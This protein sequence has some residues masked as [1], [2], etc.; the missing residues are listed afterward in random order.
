MRPKALMLAAAALAALAGA[1]RA[2]ECTVKV[3]VVMPTSVDWGKP[4]AATT[5]WVAEL[6]NEAGGVDGCRVETILRDTQVDPKVG[7]DAARALVDL[8]KVQLLLGAVSSGVSMPILTSVAV[9]AGVMQMSCC[10]SSTRFTDLAR[11]GGTRGLWF[12][13]FATSNVQAALAAMAARDRGIGTVTILYKNDDWGQDIARLVERAMAGAGVEVLGS[14]AITDGQP[15]YRA[16]VAEALGK[17]ADAL[18]LALYPKEGISVVREWISLGGTTRFIGTNSLK[19]DEFREAV[20]LKHL[21]EFV[22]TDTASPR[23]PSAA[24]F[25]E[26]Y[27]ARFGTPP[28]GPGLANAF[29]AAAIALLAYHA[30]GRDAKGADI[31]AKVA[32]VTDPQGEKV[33]GTPEGLRRAIELLSQGKS[34]SF[35]GATGAVVFDRWGDVSAPGVYWTFAEDGIRELGYVPLEEVDAFVASLN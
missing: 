7:V 22:G 5:Q 20:G 26:A 24:N 27:K 3:G 15:S 8:D 18:Y 19:S 30:A 35:Q 33:E 23:V 1:A 28:N 10:S 32:M 34:V 14:I 21:S 2:Q 6:I 31:A 12:R 13:T 4:L 25:V 9:P 16:E 17:G 11:E 29:D